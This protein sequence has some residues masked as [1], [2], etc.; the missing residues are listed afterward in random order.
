MSVGRYQ[1]TFTEFESRCYWAFEYNV[2]LDVWGLV[3]PLPTSGFLKGWSLVRNT[4]SQALPQN[5][6]RNSSRSFWCMLKFENN[7]STSFLFSLLIYTLSFSDLF[8]HSQVTVWHL[9]SFSFGPAR[10]FMLLVW[11]RRV[12]DFP[13]SFPHKHPSFISLRGGPSFWKIGRWGEDPSVNR[14]RKSQTNMV[15]NLYQICKEPVNFRGND[16]CGQAKFLGK[17]MT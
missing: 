5:W 9:T 16:F 2:L 8:K 11:G 3:Q 10:H 17:F 15:L 13:Q 7:C 1:T 4:L 6:I 14:E 12:S